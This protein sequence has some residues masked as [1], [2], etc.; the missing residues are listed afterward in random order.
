MSDFSD[1]KRGMMIDA[2]LTGASLSRTANLVGISRTTMS[3]VMTTYTNLGKVSSA[4]LDSE[5]K[6]KLMDCDRWM[7]KRRVA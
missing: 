4:K 7:L 3:R 2:R 1:V 6:L 5:R